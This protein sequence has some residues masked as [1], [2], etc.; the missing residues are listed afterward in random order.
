[1]HSATPL[2]CFVS[3]L[4]VLKIYVFPAQTAALYANYGAFF[5]FAVKIID[6]HDILVAISGGVWK[7][8]S[9][10]RKGHFQPRTFQ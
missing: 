10:L 8:S 2:V 1:M 9:L 5:I 7:L 4:C 6:N 3:L